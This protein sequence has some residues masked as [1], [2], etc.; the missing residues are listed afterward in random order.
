MRKLLFIVGV[1]GLL[2]T[3][4]LGCSSAK[5]LVSVKEA[6]L[7]RRTL[8]GLAPVAQ[9]ENGFVMVASYILSDGTKMG[10]AFDVN[11]KTILAHYFIKPGSDKISEIVIYDRGEHVVFD[12]L[13]EASRSYPDL[14]V[15]LNGSSDTLTKE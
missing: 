12:S 3:A 11:T 4:L 7:M 13:T 8:V 5:A 14:C 2:L 6:P 10:E 15:L 1:A 9:C